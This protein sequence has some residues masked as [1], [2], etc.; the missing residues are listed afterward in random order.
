MTSP[1]DQN[2]PSP[3]K[4]SNMNIDIAEFQQVVYNLEQCLYLPKSIQKVNQAQQISTQ[5][6]LPAKYRIEY[7][8][9]STPV[10][11]PCGCIVSK[12]IKNACLQESD[13]RS[14]YRGKYLE[15]HS[16]L[17]NISENTEVCPICFKATSFS[18]IGVIK[19]LLN[20]HNQLQF[21]KEKYHFAEKNDSLYSSAN[22]DDDS[23][24]QLSTPT[25]GSTLK[26]DQNR[27][28][29]SNHKDTKKSVQQNN[30]PNAIEGRAEKAS[31]HGAKNT[32]SL[33]SLFHS[34]ALN[35]TD[36]N[37]EKNS[38]EHKLTPLQEDLILGQV[39][40]SEEQPFSPGAHSIMP[41]K[42]SSQDDHSATRNTEIVAGQIFDDSVSKTKTVSLREDKSALASMDEHTSLPQLL[43]GLPTFNRYVTPPMPHDQH[44]PTGHS[45][46]PPISPS[47]QFS[48]V[49]LK[50][51]SIVEQSQN[52]NPA[53]TNNVEQTPKQPY[54]F[55]EKLQLPLLNLNS[56]FQKDQQKKSTQKA[57]GDTPL[58]YSETDENKE[59][60]YA[61]C[62]PIYRKRSQHNTH[63]KFLK[64]KSKLFIN[65][66]ISPDCTKFALIT[67]HKWEVYSIIDNQE[68]K[69]LCCGRVTGEYG[70][71]FEHLTMP[72]NIKYIIPNE[73]CASLNHTSAST[74][75]NTGYNPFKPDWDHLYCKL[76]SNLL[77]IAGTKGVLRIIDIG[78]GKG[79]PVCTFKSKFPLRCIDVD[80]NTNI[81]ACGITGKDRN[82]G[83]EQA[84]I[85]FHRVVANT[86]SPTTASFLPEPAPRFSLLQPITITLPYRDPINT[87]QFSQDGYYLS[88]STCFESRF[89]V[90]STKKIN[91]PRLV[92]KSIRSI[93]TSLESEGITDTKIFP[94]NCNLMCVTAVAFNAPPIVINTKIQSINMAS[95]HHVAQ[96]TMLL[97]LDELGSKI[98][99]CEISPRNDSIAFLDRNGSVYIMTSPTMT[100]NEK[101]RIV[102]VETCSNA[103]RLREAACM[104]FSSDGH[105]LYILDRKGIFYVEDFAAGLPQNHFVTKCKQIN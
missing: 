19:P 56:G 76:S 27:T 52:A 40:D 18:G 50:Q 28:K 61:K 104:R 105:K 77:V 90:I 80:Y 36:S 95:T 2:K 1:I 98:Y 96:P 13:V 55:T 12:K 78:A 92:M 14:F 33:I 91:E 60:F 10:Q 16:A 69:L 93:D 87:L 102:V 86:I 21:V 5:S 79:K 66:E 22:E 3:T 81:I 74:I 63:T 62:F 44:N 45:Q 88:C 6:T 83:A 65:T 7:G 29:L 39:T 59:Y 49:P 73:D 30:S 72:S 4:L 35:I 34:I 17:P 101:R 89:L 67:E 57:K 15:A 97:R 85:V 70:P 20:I 43:N 24:L 75:Y 53:H 51:P 46:Q 23:S 32:Q 42:I 94:G 47:Q 68:P 84:L 54:S 64:T 37:S 31:K 8:I 41:A 26:S 58:L 103:Y 71:D 9:V 11:L 48:T 82:S 25:A 100:D 99:K 38:L